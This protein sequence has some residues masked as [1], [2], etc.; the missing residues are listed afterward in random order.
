MLPDHHIFKSELNSKTKFYFDFNIWRKNLSLF[1]LQKSLPSGG[2]ETLFTG[3]LSS[4]STLWTCFIFKSSKKDAEQ[5]QSTN[6][7]METQ[8]LKVHHPSPQQL[9]TRSP[10]MILVA[11]GGAPG[12]VLAGF[13]GLLCTWGALTSAWIS[14]C[15]PSLTPDPISTVRPTLLWTVGTAH[16]PGLVCYASVPVPAW[17]PCLFLTDV[18]DLVAA[19]A[20]DLPLRVV[21]T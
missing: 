17:N 7:H 20:P 5:S 4:V 19:T 18:S 11:P 12:L 1:N 10:H 16:C 3:G 13:P 9:L 6:R 14:P 2:C 8:P 15:I 21:P